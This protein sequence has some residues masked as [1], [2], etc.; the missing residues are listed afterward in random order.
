MCGFAAHLKKTVS[1]I[2]R[3]G[4]KFQAQEELMDFNKAFSFQFE[5]NQWI[6]KLGLGAVISLVPILNFALSGYI[7]GIIRNVRDSSTELL[8][9]WDDLDKKFSEGLI[10]FGA[11]VVYALPLILI[12]LPIGI[13]TVAGLLSG[14]Q[15]LR[16][17]SNIIAGAGSVLLYCL[18]CLI[19][20]Y[21]LALS[22]IY[23][24]IL[25]LFAREG[26]FSSCFKFQAV[27]DLVTRNSGHFFTAW[28][29]SIA[30][31]IGVGVIIGIVNL[32]VG[33]IPCIGWI[34]SIVISFGSSIYL[35]TIYAYLFG[36]F[37]RVASGGIRSVG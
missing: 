6:S 5:D 13:M 32:L 25:V 33:W 20:I 16:D 23:P 8:P 26:T 36:E 28:L 15:N 27:F 31:G 18:L 37:G 35:L 2:L 22:V 3:I 4:S 12:F 24:A 1:S 9:N 11:G 19:L 10:L 21:A 34:V 7:V 29:V 30:A 17:I 14:N